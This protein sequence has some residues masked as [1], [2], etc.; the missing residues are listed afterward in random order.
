VIYRI[1]C[2]AAGWSAAAFA[3]PL[4]IVGLLFA[5]FAYWHA[6]SAEIGNPAVFALSVFALTT[7]QLVLLAQ[8][9]DTK[10]LHKKI[11]E[12][13]RALPEARDDLIGLETK[14]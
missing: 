8:D 14:R 12:L 7:T 1:A 6:H 11:D 5:S 2:R 9:R 4:A 10:A 13:I 3:H